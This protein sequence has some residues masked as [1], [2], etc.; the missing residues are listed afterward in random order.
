[1]DKKESPSSTGQGITYR[2]YKDTKII[3][4]IHVLCLTFRGLSGEIYPKYV[5]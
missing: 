1:M 5:R 4:H 3:S 2:Q